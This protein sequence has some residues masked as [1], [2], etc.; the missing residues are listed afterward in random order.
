[1][2]LVWSNDPENYFGGSVAT[3]SASLA[4][5]DQKG[6]PGPPGWGIGVRLT[7]SHHKIH[8]LRNVNENFGMRI[9]TMTKELE[10]GQGMLSNVQTRI[11]ERV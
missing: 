10:F 6:Y 7:T 4:R 11:A 9:K 1:M 3:G 2:G 5:Q 8:L